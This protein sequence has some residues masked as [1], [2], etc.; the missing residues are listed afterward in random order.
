MRLSEFSIAGVTTGLNSASCVP[1]G[2]FWGAVSLSLPPSRRFHVSRFRVSRSCVVSAFGGGWEGRGGDGSGLS[3]NHVIRGLSS[4]DAS[5]LPRFRTPLLP[6]FRVSVPLN[7]AF[8]LS[9]FHAF[10][11]R[12]PRLPHFH[13]STLS[14]FRTLASLASTRPRFRATQPR[15]RAFPL[16]RFRFHVFAHFHGSTLTTHV[17]LRLPARVTVIRRLLRVQLAARRHGPSS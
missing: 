11:F 4:S 14:R 8:A 5:T 12:H 9:H 13:A 16:P 17:G 1:Q 3:R 6:C 2:A 10:A 15:F 7:H